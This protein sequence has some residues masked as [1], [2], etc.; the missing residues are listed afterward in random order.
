MPGQRGETT[1][2]TALMEGVSCGA[3]PGDKAYDADWLREMLS[4][5]QVGPL[6][7]QIITKI[8]V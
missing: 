4:I 7:G 2:V 6:I 3:F 1:G 5:A 8:E